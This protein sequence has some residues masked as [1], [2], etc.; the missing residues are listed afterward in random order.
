MSSASDGSAVE[1][2]G[3]N[4]TV[5]D[6]RPK[7]VS[8]FDGDAAFYATKE[9]NPDVVEALKRLVALAE[10]G[11]LQGFAAAYVSGDD[12]V[13]STQA[14]AMTISLVGMVSILHHEMAQDAL[15]CRQ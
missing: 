3:V 14:G 15:E 1:P 2:A 12:Y 6:S 9:P 5:T 7:V 13:S 8:L 4:A 11:E 10:T